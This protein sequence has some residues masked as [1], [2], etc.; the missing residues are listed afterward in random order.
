MLNSKSYTFIANEKENIADNLEKLNQFLKTNVYNQ[1]KNKKEEARMMKPIKRNLTEEINLID[2]KINTK[3]QFPT[4]IPENIT[5]THQKYDF[6]AVENKKL[7]ET[8]SED[9]FAHLL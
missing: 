6:K 3:T 8:Y 1:D 7:L 5:L 2:S 4:S 9:I